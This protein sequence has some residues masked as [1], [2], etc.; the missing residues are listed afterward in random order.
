MNIGIDMDSVIADIM[1][2]LVRFHNAYY[3]TKNVVEDHDTYALSAVWKCSEQEAIKRVF[4]FYFSP[5]YDRIKPLRYSRSG[6]RYLARKYSLFVVTARPFEIEKKSLKWLDRYFPG[7]F[8]DVIHTNILSRKGWNNFKKSDICV[9]LDISVIIEDS[10]D[11]AK[12]CASANI[13]SYLLNMPWN[14]S[15]VRKKNIVR[16]KSWKDIRNVL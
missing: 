16:L 5:Y 15:E 9:H 10:L 14:Q 3:G 1:P 13:R 2:E 12:D 7:M 11:F 8:K 6:I 4:K